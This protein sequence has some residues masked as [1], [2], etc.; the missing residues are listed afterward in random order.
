MTR[1]TAA[2]SRRP[3]SDGATVV[4]AVTVIMG[5]VVGLTF[6]SGS[7]TSSTSPCDSVCPSGSHP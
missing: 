4:H 2:S 1:P 3:G 6:S 5:I 7:V